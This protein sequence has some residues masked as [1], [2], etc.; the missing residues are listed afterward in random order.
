MYNKIYD[1]IK[2]K[3]FSINSKNG[4]KVLRN[5][6]NQLKGGGEMKE[7]DLPERFP[8]DLDSLLSD[9]I[10][11]PTDKTEGKDRRR[12]HDSELYQRLNERIRELIPT[13]VDHEDFHLLENPDIDENDPY[14]IYKVLLQFLQASLFNVFEQIV[15]FDVAEKFT[16]ENF[17]FPQKSF[18]SLL[19]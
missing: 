19:E 13:P 8:E 6:I 15:L 17:N 5:Y 16:R 14:M 2:N 9:L 12:I 3:Y 18:I 11:I 7:H 4:K 1:P 10:V